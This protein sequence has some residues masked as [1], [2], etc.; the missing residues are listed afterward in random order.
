MQEYFSDCDFCLELRRE[1]EGLFPKLAIDKSVSRIVLEAGHL[2]VFP[3]LG[4]ILPGHL[5]IAPTYHVT[6]S[7]NLDAEDKS[8]LF[9]LMNKISR[10]FMREHGEY[11]VYFEHGDPTG[12]EMAYGQC[13]SHAHIHVLPVFVNMLDRLRTERPL[14]GGS[15]SQDSTV[16]ITE[17]YVSFIDGSNLQTHYF[18]A[19]GAPRQYMRALYSELVG[20]A[21]AQDWFSRINIETTIHNAQKYTRIFSNIE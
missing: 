7:I 12:H 3:S 16:R 9:Q 18:S 4:E 8:I 20:K 17:P 10:A 1:P 15:N 21:G 11:P 14:I 19:V 6:A 13:I 2:R 5:L